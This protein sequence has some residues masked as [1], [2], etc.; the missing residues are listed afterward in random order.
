[1][2]PCNTGCRQE[3]SDMLGYGCLVDSIDTEREETSV[4]WHLS[5]REIVR[6]RAKREGALATA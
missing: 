3:Q 4:V 5:C 1:M 2:R 6:A